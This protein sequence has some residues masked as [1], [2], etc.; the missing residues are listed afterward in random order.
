MRRILFILLTGAAVLALAGAPSRA[1]KPVRTLILGAYTVPKEAYQREIIPAFQAYWKQKT[2]QEVKFEESYQASGAQA[3]AIV[4]GFEADVA[5]LSLD[6][7]LDKVARAGLI[8]HNYRD[9]PQKG[10]VTQSVVVIGYRPG[11]PKKI[12]DWEDLGEPGLEIIYPNPK[13]SGGAMWCV[14]AIYGAGL[15][16]SEAN[17]GQANSDYAFKLLQRIQHNVKVM[18]KSGRESVTTF[19][20]GVGDAIVT[21]ENEALL[22]QME[23]RDFP[24]IVPRATILIENPIA[25]VDRNVDKH[26]TRDLA[27]AFVEFCR[28]EP[29][30][31]SFAK[32]G[33]RPV[34]PRIAAEFAQKFPVPEMLFDMSFLGGWEG[35]EKTIYGPDGAWT[36][37]L[38]TAAGK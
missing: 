27:E 36:R 12:R 17:D 20:R 11:N 6:G 38:E 3:R 13:T 30:Q 33:L 37:S 14:N 4:G 25:V 16:Y 15:K 18:D 23:G 1:Q 5:A 22:R 35:V 2:G 21:Y 28:T 26:G 24:F 19:E 7:D 29:A 9:N 34:L 31:R 8:T 32:F 10:M